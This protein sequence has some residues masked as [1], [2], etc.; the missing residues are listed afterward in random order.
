[1]TKIIA[2]KTHSVSSKHLG[3]DDPIRLPALSSLLILILIAYL[4]GLIA[5]LKFLIPQYKTAKREL[6]I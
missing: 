5:S 6:S 3:E 2:L 4:Y 1:M